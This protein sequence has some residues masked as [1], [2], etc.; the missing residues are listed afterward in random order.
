MVELPLQPDRGGGEIVRRLRSRG[1]TVC[2]YGRL[3]ADLHR[4]AD[5][6][7]VIVGADCRKAVVPFH[8]LQM[9]HAPAVPAF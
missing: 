8:G 5:T 2:S 6:V 9:Y 4:F 7:A 1:D 3:A